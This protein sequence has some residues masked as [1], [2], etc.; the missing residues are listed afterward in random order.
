MICQVLGM[1]PGGPVSSGLLQVGIRKGTCDTRGSSP[2]AGLQSSSLLEPPG[3]FRAS[4]RCSRTA[5]SMSRVADHSWSEPRPRR[6]VPGA[7]SVPAGHR[8]GS[9]SLQEAMLPCRQHRHQLRCLRFRLCPRPGKIKT[10]LPLLHGTWPCPG[11][12]NFLHLPWAPAPPAG[13]LL[14]L[15]SALGRAFLSSHLVPSQDPAPWCWCPHQT[16]AQ[17]S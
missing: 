7:D 4:R 11:S 13:K 15:M 12:A 1:A 5:V 9:R 6:A 16:P 8:Q 17:P 2:S 10:S 14:P 3:R